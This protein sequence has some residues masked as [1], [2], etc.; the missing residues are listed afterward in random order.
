MNRPEA[1]GGE[2]VKS[3]AAAQESLERLEAGTEATEK[4]QELDQTTKDG[5]EVGRP[6][7]SVMLRLILTMVWRRLIRNPNTYA[8]VVGLVWSLIEF[9]YV[10]HLLLRSIRDQS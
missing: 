5:G 8:S 1:T 7:A 4:E 6:P 9:R 10:I 2:R 3:E